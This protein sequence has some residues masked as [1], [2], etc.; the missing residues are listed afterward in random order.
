MTNS[1]QTWTKDNF[2]DE[3]DIVRSSILEY[4]FNETGNYPGSRS[5]Q[6]DQSFANYLSQR[7]ANVIGAKTINFF[8]DSFRFQICTED[9][10]TWVHSDPVDWTAILYL[11]PNAPTA[12]GTGLYQH[13]SGISYSPSYLDDIGYVFDD[14]SCIYEFENVYNR[15]IVFP[16]KHYHRSQRAGFG[17]DKY[18]ARLTQ[19]F[20]FSYTP[21]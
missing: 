14:W 1:I 9:A 10:K 12:A 16:G 6:V 5:A 21:L 19:V 11:T 8:K 2:L 13:K 20:F 17:N 15:L 3:P 7:L 4:D 18:T